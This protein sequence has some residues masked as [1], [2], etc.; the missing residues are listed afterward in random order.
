MP[1]T[2]VF[3]A[4]PLAR[5]MPD[6]FASLTERGIEIAFH[7]GSGI[8]PRAEL[9][10][11]L[12][13]V[14]AAVAGLEAYDGAVFDARPD[15]RIVSR[16][17]VGYETV[18]LAAALDRGVKV[19]ITPAANSASVADFAFSLVL[20]L[21]RR[22]VPAHNELQHGVWRRQIGTEL[23][24]KT[25]GI[26]GLGRI[27]KR[28]ARR[29]LGFDMRVVAHDIAP[30]HAFAA[31]H[32]VAWR[33]L[34]ELLA[35]SDVVTLHVPLTR[36]TRGMIN[37]ASLAGVK[38]G[39]LLINTARGGIMHAA[40]VARALDDG[41]LSGA[42]VDVPAV[43]GEADPELLERPNVI[44][45]PHMGASTSEAM[46]RMM[47]DAAQNILDVM[48]GLSPEGLLTRDALALV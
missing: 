42:G 16:V 12:D 1:I 23:A 48:D 44:L 45:T 4:H 25:L 32:G 11:V 39:A 9:V 2:R 19:L 33:S 47:R 31:A 3:A 6:A 18:D 10:R 38:R 28:V 5:T 37:D 30:D 15:L 20:A 8:V 17:G 40:A 27:G 36:L 34:P 35:E 22:I 29:A 7:H 41:R 14:Q 24:G 26:V 21:A 43:E 13:G 46:F